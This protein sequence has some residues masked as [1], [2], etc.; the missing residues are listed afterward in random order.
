MIKSYHK[1]NIKSIITQF[2]F[3]HRLIMEANKMNYSTR[4][5][6]GCSQNLRPFSCC[7][8]DFLNHNCCNSSQNWQR[9]QPCHN[10]CHNWHNQCNCNQ[11]YDY[12]QPCT[13]NNLLFFMT[14]YLLAKNCK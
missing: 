7:C 6:P 12:N 5:C 11:R 2:F 3:S 8:N 9:C 14:G 13:N 1:N 4:Y 10:N